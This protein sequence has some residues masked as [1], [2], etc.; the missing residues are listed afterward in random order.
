MQ[1]Q[2][3]SVYPVNP[4][5]YVYARLDS[6]DRYDTADYVGDSIDGD[7]VYT[8][9]VREL[10]DTYV[11]DVGIPLTVIGG[12]LVVPVSAAWDDIMTLDGGHV[13][14]AD[15]ECDDYICVVRTCPDLMVVPVY[16]DGG[17][18]VF[19]DLLS[20]CCNE[21]VLVHYYYGLVL[22]HYQDCADLVS[23]DP[24]VFFG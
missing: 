10:A 1:Y 4:D 9:Q 16:R 17:Y 18:F 11:R 22:E 15:Y 5:Q 2:Y 24:L 12:R 14:D 21:D 13:D 6:P 7:A 20:S 23:D 3:T 19:S 8:V